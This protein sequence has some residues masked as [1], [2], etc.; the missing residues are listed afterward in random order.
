[1]SEH[2]CPKFEGAISILGK[3]W[4]GLILHVLLRG[5][6]R[7]KEIREIVPQ[8]SDKMLSE[9]LKELEEQ[10][11]IERKVYPEIPVRIEYHLTEKGKD[12]RSVIES[13]E[14]WSHKW[15]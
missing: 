14:S 10:G 13:I 12:L 11:V 1:M 3:R 5:P 15:M 8:M 2:M 9:R 4:T 6:A 7:F